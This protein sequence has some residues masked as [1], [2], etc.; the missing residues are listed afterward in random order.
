MALIENTLEGRI[1]KVDIAIER[2]KAYAPI[3]KGTHPE[4]YYVAYS[5]GKDSD[6]IRILTELA[7][8]KHDLVHNHTTVDAPETVYYVRSIP[9]IIINYPNTTMWKLIVKNK[10]PPTRVA[11]YCCAELKEQGGQD[12]FVMTGVRREESAKRAN[13]QSFETLAT[14]SKRLYLNVD[15]DENRRQIERCIS[16]G[17]IVLNPIIDWTTDDVWEFLHHYNCKSNPLY[18]CGY[19]RVGCVGCPMAGREGRLREFERYPKY[20]LNYI[21]AFN[22]M[23][24]ARDSPT[25]TWKSGQDVFDWWVS[26]K[27]EQIDENQLRLFDEDE[28]V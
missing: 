21:K 24:A 16:Q 28:S 20:K 23:L 8:V 6:C 12:R 9:N 19:K 25:T 2:I 5:G 3:E 15:N 26:P 10:I 14:K 1:N 11:R 18:Q 22:R 4:P 13:R 7:G 27:A 17:K